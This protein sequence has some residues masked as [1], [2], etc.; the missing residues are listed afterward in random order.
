MLPECSL[1]GGSIL[2]SRSALHAPR[3]SQSVLCSGE[4]FCASGALSLLRCAPGAFSMLRG[5]SGAFA[6]CRVPPS[7]RGIRAVFGSKRVHR[8]SLGLER[9]LC[10]S[11]LF[12]SRGTFESS[13]KCD[14]EIGV[15]TRLSP[16][17]QKGWRKRHPFLA[18]RLLIK[19]L[20]EKMSLALSWE[21]SPLCVLPV[22]G[23]ALLF[24]RWHL[25]FPQHAFFI[26]ARLRTLRDGPREAHL[27]LP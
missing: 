23:C 6:A 26:E 5:A 15:R 2:C 20:F 7:S 9:S 8:T 1:L 17:K 25:S 16:R 27:Y 10:S 11:P 12:S 21:T 3:C 4:A 13:P 14:Y 24:R 22:S 18:A 19:T